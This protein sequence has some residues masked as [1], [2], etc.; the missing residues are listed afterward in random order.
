MR[1]EDLIYREQQKTYFILIVVFII[2]A[3]FLL[4][5]VLFPELFRQQKISLLFKI[6]L[7]I[8]TIIDLAMFWSFSKLTIKITSEY[9]QIGFG[10]FKKKI[11]LAQISETLVEDYVRSNY[12]GYGI[13]F[14]RDKSIG[15]IARGGRGVRIK[16]NS[17]DYF[18][19]S[20]NPEQIQSLLKSRI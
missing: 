10:V 17:K 5:I 9:L 11:V 1:N 13:R 19:S 3:I 14:G 16:T 12:L 18:F 20:D 4:G 15:F 8:A 2:I 7:F 6:V